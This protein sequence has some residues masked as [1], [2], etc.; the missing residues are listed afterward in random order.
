MTTMQFQYVPKEIEEVH[1]E[2]TSKPHKEG[3]DFDISNPS[4]EVLRKVSNKKPTP[5]LSKERA[6][7]LNKAF[8]QALSNE[9]K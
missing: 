3:E 4:S 9:M 1:F 8:Q 2:S 6:T 5:E 7:V